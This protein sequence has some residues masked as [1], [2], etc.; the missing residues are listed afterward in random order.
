MPVFDVGKFGAVGDGVTLDTAAI[1]RAIDAAAA[2]G[3]ATVLFPSGNYL[4]YSIH[5]KSNVGL[6]LESGATIIAADAPAA[7][8]AGY[9]LAEPNQ[10]NM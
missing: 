7:G 1:Q 9:D 10:W 2:A 3:G 6:H 8:A 5:L 4:S